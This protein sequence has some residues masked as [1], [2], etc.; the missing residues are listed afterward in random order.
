MNLRRIAV[1]VVAL[2]AA[3]IVVVIAGMTFMGVFGRDEPSKDDPA[4]YTKAFV[5]KAIERYERDG[6]QATIDYY[7]APGNRDGQ[8]YA[9]IID[10]NGYTISHLNPEIRGR[11]PALRVDVTGYFFGDELL[12]ATAEG[13]WAEYVAVNPETGNHQK[14]STPT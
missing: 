9:M 4:A 2:V 5:Q 13:R 14:M 12:A 6:R 11:D 3:V 1:V 8:W 7:N 10:E